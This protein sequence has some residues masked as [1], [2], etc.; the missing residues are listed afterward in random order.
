MNCELCSSNHSD[1]IKCHECHA[2]V[3]T[4]CSAEP[5][6]AITLRRLT[7]IE[8]L[9]CCDRRLVCQ[10]RSSIAVLLPLKTHALVTHC[11]CMQSLHPAIVIEYRCRVVSWRQLVCAPRWPT[12]ALDR[13]VSCNRQNSATV[14]TH[15]TIVPMQRVCRSGAKSAGEYVEY[16]TQPVTQNTS[17][18]V[19][20]P[21]SLMVHGP[22]RR[23]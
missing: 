21:K 19:E 2:S 22:H 3:S 6:L 8:K 14:V 11:P 23:L 13:T 16:L 7:L 17:Q 9:V 20:L 10:S 15:T 18:H 12:A 1:S 5:R 4:R